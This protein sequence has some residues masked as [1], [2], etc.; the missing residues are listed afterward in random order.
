MKAQWVLAWAQSNRR[1][2]VP[3]LPPGVRAATPE[4]K[5]AAVRELCLPRLLKGPREI[6]RVGDSG[7]V[8]ARNQSRPLSKAAVHLAED[9][10]VTS[11]VILVPALVL[12]GH[13]ALT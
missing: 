1:P 13:L 4:T 8:G 5:P 11:P 3:R 9:Q 12:H 2:R 10:K 6:P 7:S